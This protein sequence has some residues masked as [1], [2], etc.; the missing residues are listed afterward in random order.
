MAL[1]PLPY[2]PARCTLLGQCSRPDLSPDLGQWLLGARMDR[3]RTAEPSKSWSVKEAGA[4]YGYVVNRW[5]DNLPLTWFPP[6]V[7][8]QGFKGHQKSWS[9]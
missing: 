8:L 3:M 5:V 9:S 1:E 4:S 2:A 7:H 6:S